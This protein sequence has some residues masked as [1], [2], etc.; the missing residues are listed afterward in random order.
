M[1]WWPKNTILLRK[2]TLR[3]QFEASDIVIKSRQ[4]V[5]LTPT[6][7]RNIRRT[8]AHHRRGTVSYQ[9]LP[10]GMQA[11]LRPSLAHGKKGGQEDTVLTINNPFRFRRIKGIGKERMTVSIMHKQH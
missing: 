4:R 8:I 9:R 7:E 11:S 6:L 10:I 3:K 2:T 1:I 5:S